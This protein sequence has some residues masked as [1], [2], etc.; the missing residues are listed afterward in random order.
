MRNH[1]YVRLEIIN[2]NAGVAVSQTN[3]T[4]QSLSQGSVTLRFSTTS[5]FKTRRVLNRDVQLFQ[6]DDATTRTA[7]ITMGWLDR[8]F[9]DRLISR[10]GDPECSLYSLDLNTHICCCIKY[11]LPIHKPGA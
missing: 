9:P 8:I 10:H 5:R 4:R 3:T 11:T 2:R 6:H 1:C 7:N